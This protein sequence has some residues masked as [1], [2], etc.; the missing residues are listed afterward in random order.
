MS[1]LF[2]SDLHLEDSRPQM[3][4]MFRQFLLGPATEAEAVYVLGDLFEFWIGDD[5]LSDTAIQVAEAFSGLHGRG[6]PAYFMHGNR[7]FLL[8]QKYAEQAS[9]NLL[10]ET[11]VVNLDDT[12]CLLLHGDSL[13]TD[14]EAYQAFRKQV[15]QPEFQLQFLSMSV[16]KRLEVAQNARDASKRHTGS[17]AMDIMDVNQEAVDRAF[18]EHQVA[19]MIHGHTHR[20]AFHDHKLSNGRSGQRIVLS[21]WYQSGSYLRSNNDGFDAMTIDDA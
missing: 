18:K 20:P 3:T 2:I 13:C 19:H 14:D 10:P 21:D 9:L 15:R 4:A 16:E 12:P 1:T 17:V 5:V 6:V 7:D 8:G 11:C